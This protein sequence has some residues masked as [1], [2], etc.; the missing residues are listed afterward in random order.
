MSK[1]QRVNF[2][3][4]N[5][6]CAIC[7]TQIGLMNLFEWLPKREEDL[8]F[9]MIHPNC[10]KDI[11]FENKKIYENKR[12]IPTE[13]DETMKA[14]CS[15]C[16]KIAEKVN[17]EG[18][19]VCSEHL[20]QQQQQQ[21]FDIH[22]IAKELKKYISIED[23]EQIVQ[24]REKIK[25]LNLETIVDDVREKILGAEESAKR[26]NDELDVLNDLIEEQKNKIVPKNINII[27]NN[28]YTT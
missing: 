2:E 10:R 5:S 17:K 28:R 1:E 14:N 15:V 27:I 8:G 7:N 3:S 18:S 21:P 22:E 23:L 24:T 20:H 25:D 12:Y 13:Q 16:G 11:S 9:R 6:I 19:W 4:K 26:I